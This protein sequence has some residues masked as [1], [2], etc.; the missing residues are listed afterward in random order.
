M[1]DHHYKISLKWTGNKG[2]GTLNYKAYSR[3]H[4]ISIEDKQIEIPVSSDPSFLGDKTRYNPEELLL[5][6]LSSCH[7]LW[8]LHLCAVNKVIVTDYKDKAIG[9]MEEQSDGSGRFKEAI[10]NPVVCIENIEMVEKAKALH[11]DAHKMCFIAN[12]INFVVKHNPQIILKS[13]Q[14][15]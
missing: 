14:T 10:L 6:S 3:D 4:S 13:S 7:M 12:S 5:A 9:T 11:N 1:R 8:Y 2:N 15:P